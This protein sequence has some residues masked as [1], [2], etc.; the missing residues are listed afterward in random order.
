MNHFYT[1]PYKDK[2]QWKVDKKSTTSKKTIETFNFHT[3]KLA[4]EFLETK[5]I[6]IDGKLVYSGV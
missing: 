6:Y 2:S 3:E 4:I 5:N 1:S